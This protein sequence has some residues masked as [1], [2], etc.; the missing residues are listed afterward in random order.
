M[1]PW[2]SPGSGGRRRSLARCLYEGL[3]CAAPAAAGRIRPGLRRIADDVG[4]AD[5]APGLAGDPLLD[6]RAGLPDRVAGCGG[7]TA[8]DAVRI[9]DRFLLPEPHGVAGVGAG[10]R[11]NLGLL[12]GADSLQLDVSE[13][14]LVRIGRTGVC[15]VGVCRLRLLSASA[16]PTARA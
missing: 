4:P 16:G 6:V 9:P 2:H 3:G 1:P 10:V 12:A 5:A 15:V 7:A 11:G 14:P 13:V 8:Q